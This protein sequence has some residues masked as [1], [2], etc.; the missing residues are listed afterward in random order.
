MKWI[1]VIFPVLLAAAAALSACSTVP[2]EYTTQTNTITIPATGGLYLES[3]IAIPAQAQ[4]AKLVFDEVTVYYT[5]RKNATYAAHVALYATEKT[6]ANQI[7]SS[8]ETLADV[9]MSL[10][11][12]VYS[13]S[14]VSQDLK[15]RLNAHA[16]VIVMGAENLNLNP[17]GSVTI[18][19]TVK[20]KGGYRLF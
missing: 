17:L 13:G 19:I 15:N 5:V 18:D 10:T 1:R 4:D 12:T 11:D 7:K 8:P 2:F 16:P 14:T 20:I 9:T 3:E 6:A